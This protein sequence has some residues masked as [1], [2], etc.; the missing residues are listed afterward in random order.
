MT[1]DDNLIDKDGNVDEDELDRRI[2]EAGLDQ[3]PS[4]E[5][6]REE[7]AK[8]DDEFDV[9]LRALEEK[10]K[11]HNAVRDSKAHET[12]RRME[13]DRENARGLGVGLSIA[14]TLIGLPMLGL[15]VG[16]FLDQR[17][18]STS[19]RSYGVLIGAIFGIVMTFVMLSRT[20]REP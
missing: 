7:A 17:T 9:R 20:N 11:S 5:K 6:A 12:K 13:S 18:G 3:T 2:R 15:I 16:W 8:I 19:Y 10:A 14:Y 4:I 1:D